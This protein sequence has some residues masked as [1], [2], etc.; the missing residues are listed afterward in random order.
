MH[1]SLKFILTSSAGSTFYSH[2]GL[3]DLAESEWL[4]WSN[5]ATQ[6]RS[7]LDT[8]EGCARSYVGAE[9]A[10]GE[11]GGAGKAVRREQSGAAEQEEGRARREP[12]TSA[13]Q[14]RDASA[15]HVPIPESASAH[16]RDPSALSNRGDGLI[17]RCYS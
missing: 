15:P 6:R 2:G 16:A 1:S 7:G 12:A 3:T 8:Q 10:R 9:A 11:R 17:Q 4:A 13:P 14:R 5:A